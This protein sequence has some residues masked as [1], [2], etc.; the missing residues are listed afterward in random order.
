MASPVSFLSSRLAALSLYPDGSVSQS[1]S[2]PALP[3]FPPSTTPARAWGSTSDLS[4]RHEGFHTAI[5]HFVRQSSA[6]PLRPASRSPLSVSSDV[7]FS[8][9]EPP[10]VFKPGSDAA[11]RGP[12]AYTLMELH[13]LGDAVRPTKAGRV[14]QLVASCD[15]DARYIVKKDAQKKSWVLD[16]KS[17]IAISVYSDHIVCKGKRYRLEAGEFGIYTLEKIASV[18]D[19]YLNKSFS[20]VDDSLIPDGVTNGPRIHIESEDDVRVRVDGCEYEISREGS[21][22]YLQLVDVE[23]DMQGEFYYFKNIGLASCDE[24]MELFTDGSRRYVERD[25]ACYDL[26][27][28]AQKGVYSLLAKDVE[29]A[30][31][32]KV[33]P[34]Y[35][36]LDITKASDERQQFYERINMSA[37]IKA[38]VATLILRPQ[39][40]KIFELDESNYLFEEGVDKQLRPVLIDLDETLPDSNEAH[41]G[42]ERVRTGLMGFPQARVILTGPLKNEVVSL[43]QSIVDKSHEG[44]GYLEQVLDSDVA[45]SY[46]EAVGNISKFLSMPCE[47]FTLQNVLFS[48]F[49]GYK[50]QWDILM[51]S[52]DSPEN[53]ALLVGFESLSDD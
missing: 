40:G 42:V 36:G 45:A 31:Q 21:R 30:F 53:V 2:C 38:F 46:E 3:Y 15:I 20:L 33:E 8:A 13:G 1:A 26:I 4:S 35:R 6:S 9:T 32:V 47:P 10:V 23:E 43:L 52:M 19:Q 22:F 39:D 17:L 48:L 18:I 5:D 28:T 27:E 7:Y 25:D 37:F 16:E 50:K 51:Q 49:P 24:C 11:E 29:G 44:K 14:H 12:I 34:I 41:D